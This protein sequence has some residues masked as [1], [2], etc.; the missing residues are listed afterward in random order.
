MKARKRPPVWQIAR[1]AREP[2]E[3][4]DRIVRFLAWAIVLGVAG[5]LAWVLVNHLGGQ[6]R[7]IKKF[8]TPPPEVRLFEPA[9]ERAT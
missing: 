9:G 3:W 6:F 4:S 7:K 2:G 1:G 8:Y 5:Y